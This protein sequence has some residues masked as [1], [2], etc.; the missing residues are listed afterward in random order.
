[1]CFGCSSCIILFNALSIAIASAEFMEHV[2]GSL[3]NRFL[4]GNITDE[5][6]QKMCESL[7]KKYS[8]LRNQITPEER[9]TV[10]RR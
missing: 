8:Q 7:S 4:F 2:L 3:N 9:L 6:L 5:L 1:M 10:T